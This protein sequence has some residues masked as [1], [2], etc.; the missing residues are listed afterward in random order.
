MIRLAYNLALGVGVALAAPMLG[1][2]LARGR[3]R[4]IALARL[5]LGSAWLP[6]ASPGCIW[7]HALSVGEVRS[8][9]PLLKSLQK[10]F[11]QRG[12][13]L[14]V[15]TAQGLAVARQEMA[16]LPGV[17][18]FVRPLDLAWNVARLLDRL[19]PGLFILV[20]GD[21]WPGWQWGLARRGVP[22]LLVNGRVSPRTFKGYQRFRRAA[23]SLFGGFDRVL[24]QTRVDHERLLAVGLEPA[25]LAVGGNLKFD[26]APQPLDLAQRQ[27]L[28]RELGL[29]G[30]TVLAAGS[31]HPGE[32]EPCLE[33]FQALAPRHPG[34]ALLLAPRQ[35]DRGRALARLAQE[36]G[37][38]AACLSQGAPDPGAQ[39]VILDL[40]GKLAPAYALARAAFVGGS[41]TPV[42][43]HNLLEPAAQGVPVLYGPHTH[44]FLEMARD[45]EAA[46]GGRRLA[47]PGDL[48]PAWGEFL[49]HPDRA[50]SMGQ[51]GQEFCRAHGGALARAVQEAARLLPG[52]AA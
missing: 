21:I 40:L 52:D 18:L 7:V 36:R 14:S 20:E 1:A 15:A 33:A 19:R 5:G 48:A 35:V 27:A 44:N 51:A 9:L 30:R 50:R 26:S 24:V 49:D 8:A 47:G 17:T 37:L 38:S 4:A 43:G 46:G 34:L 13:A 42:G 12:L 28:A 6:P 39:V 11:P 22:S 16:G 10:R 29:E 32:E 31:T 41:L 45:L 3:Y 2:R 23:L 25:R